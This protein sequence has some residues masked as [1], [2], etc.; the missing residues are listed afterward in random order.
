MKT[1][2]S[3]IPLQNPNVLFVRSP[4]QYVAILPRINNFSGENIISG[5]YSV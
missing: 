1:E 4:F 3:K 2:N 5:N